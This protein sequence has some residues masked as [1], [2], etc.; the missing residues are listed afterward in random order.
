MIVHVVIGI[1][2]AEL[3]ELWL[4]YQNPSRLTAGS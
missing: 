3:A 1:I 2:V 4:R